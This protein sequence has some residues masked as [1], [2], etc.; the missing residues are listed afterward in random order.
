MQINTNDNNNNY[1]EGSARAI[2][3]ALFECGLPTTM[4]KHCSQLSATYYY[5]FFPLSLFSPNQ[6]KNMYYIML[7]LFLCLVL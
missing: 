1:H 3:I 7:L 6:I 2:W 5:Y 4:S